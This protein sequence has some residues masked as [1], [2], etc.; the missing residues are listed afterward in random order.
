MTV[1]LYKEG[2]LSPFIEF[3]EQTVHFE[4]G[5]ESKTFSYRFRIG[6]VDF[7]GGNYEGRIVAVEVPPGQAGQ[8]STSAVAGVATQV[9]LRVPK[10]GKHIDAKLEIGEAQAG[11]EVNFII[12]AT[13]IGTEKTE[14]SG[15]VE[16]YEGQNLLDTIE[17]NSLEL[18][19]QERNAMKAEWIANQ[20]GSY[21]A[22]AIISYDGKQE[23]MEKDFVVGGFMIEIKR[24]FVKNYR[25]NEIAKIAM[26]VESRWNE[27]IE[28]VYGDF[29]I[30]SETGDVVGEFRSA[31]ID[32][33]PRSTETI[34][35]YWDTEGVSEG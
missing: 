24:I 10:P 22:K 30:S 4:E 31:S 21:K 5:E 14:V 15:K 33:E 2:I 19:S 8:T 16:V 13:N 9:I 32:L 11:G 20:A 25:L 12:S 29:I 18:E 3:P 1:R 17:T 26:V 7:T 6:L 27:I 34:H 35:A 23:V 28:D